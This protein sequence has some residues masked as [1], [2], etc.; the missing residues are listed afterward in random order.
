MARRLSIKRISDFITRKVKESKVVQF[1]LRKV[2][3][4]R[5]RPLFNQIRQEML[6]EF[7]N[8]EIT[9]EIDM[10]PK[11]GY[12][13]K[14][15]RGYGDLFSFIGF[16]RNDNPTEPVRKLIKGMRLFSVTSKGL[17][18]IYEVR[19]FPTSA[20]IFAVTPM[21]WKDGKSWAKGIEEGI[22]GLGRYL[23]I[24]TD[25]NPPDLRST[26]GI[27]VKTKQT[28]R[29]PFVP[30]K[31]ISEIVNKYRNQFLAISNTK[32]IPIKTE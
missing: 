29:A 11:L 26:A 24:A 21:P 4:L 28:F 8:H 5:I 2:V 22:S 13:S 10:G 27:Q 20:D 6:D 7:D 3:E 32:V 15:L 12:Q 14:F 19:N 17:D 30:T 31:Y 25:Y 1:A 18:W 23:N 16:D 9:K